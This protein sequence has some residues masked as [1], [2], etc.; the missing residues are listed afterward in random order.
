MQFAVAA[1][2]HA[3][4]SPIR[5]LAGISTTD[6]QWSSWLVLAVQLT[7]MGLILRAWIGPWILRAVLHRVRVRSISPRS[8][9]GIRIRSGGLTIR[10]DRL[11][12]SYHSLSSR[13]ARRFSLQVQGLHVEVNEVLCKPPPSPSTYPVPTTPKRRFSRRPTLSDFRP[14]PLW[15]RF[16]SFYSY[17]YETIAPYVRPFLRTVFVTSSRIVIRCL[18][19]LTHIVDLEM[20]RLLVT[21]PGLPEAHVVIHNATLS[22]TVSFTNLEGFIAIDPSDVPPQR[23]HQGFL[24]MMHFKARFGGSARR[25]WERA[26][27]RTQGAASFELKIGKVSVYTSDT[28]WPFPRRASLVEQESSSQFVASKFDFVTSRPHE[29][30]I[31]VSLPTETI[32]ATSF[33]FGPKRAIIENQSVETSLEVSTI[34]VVTDRFMELVHCVRG[35]GNPDDHFAT[36]PQSPVLSSDLIV[37]RLACSFG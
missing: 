22:T 15:R 11:G 18:P 4:C 8:I 1:F 6:W 21:F 30:A 10:V 31:C 34:H 7:V 37:V 23:V 17:T 32:F 33:K 27:G 28:K 9:R 14:S 3:V 25:V 36:T 2:W 16:W 35:N 20:D 29:E 24:N 13:A 12:I 26:W 19:A 5:F